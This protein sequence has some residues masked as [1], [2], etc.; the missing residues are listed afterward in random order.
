[1]SHKSHLLLLASWAVCCVGTNQEEKLCRADIVFVVD[2]SGSVDGAD[3][4][5]ALRFVESIVKV[6]LCEVS[7]NT[8]P[9]VRCIKGCERRVSPRLVCL[10]PGCNCYVSSLR[11]ARLQ[12]RSSIQ[13]SPSVENRVWVGARFSVTFYL[14]VWEAEITSTS[15]ALHF[16]AAKER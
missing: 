3:L 2:A 16:A 8:L 7:A 4:Q 10:F 15:F 12:D 1:M 5:K 13:L 9:S 11:S 14:L 6:K